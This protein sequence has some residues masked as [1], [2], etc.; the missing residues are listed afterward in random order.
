MTD[1][2]IYECPN[3]GVEVQSTI[4]DVVKRTL[5][6]IHAKTKCPICLCNCLV[7]IPITEFL[8]N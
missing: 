4:W 7:Y 5:T 8:K 2:V 1:Q 6:Y 3:C